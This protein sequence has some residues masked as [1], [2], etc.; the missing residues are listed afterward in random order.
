MDCNRVTLYSMLDAMVVLPPRN[1][2]Y[3]PD[4]WQNNCS[5]K[6]NN[7]VFFNFEVKTARNSILVTDG[8]NKE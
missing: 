6:N 2:Q 7:S 8:Q 3:L 4:S 1:R 5:A